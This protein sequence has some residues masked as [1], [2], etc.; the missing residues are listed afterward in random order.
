MVTTQ[1]FLPNSW[2]F[3]DFPGYFYIFS[4]KRNRRIQGLPRANSKTKETSRPFQ[5]KLLHKSKKFR[6]M[7]L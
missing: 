2:T 5:D 3:Q 1:I 7:S 4:R 6:E